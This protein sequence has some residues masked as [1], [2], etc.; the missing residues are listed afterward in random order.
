MQNS[1]GNQNDPSRSS[2]T[3]TKTVISH[4][5]T[6]YIIFGVALLVFVI[7]IIV[8]VNLLKRKNANPGYT[9][10]ST[11]YGYGMP[12]GSDDNNPHEN[13]KGHIVVGSGGPANGLNYTPDIVQQSTAL[14]KRSQS[15]QY[16][17]QHHSLNSAMT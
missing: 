9:L 17:Q 12:P 6:L 7:V 8:I 4:D 1:K 3:T 2:E 10:T 14:L 5:V 16:T 11:D 13:K 15:N